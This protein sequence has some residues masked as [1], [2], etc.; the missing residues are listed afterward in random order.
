MGRLLFASSLHWNIAIEVLRCGLSQTPIRLFWL[1]ALDNSRFELSLTQSE[2]TVQW[3]VHSSRRHL[4]KEDAEALRILFQ[5]I[6][7]VVAIHGLLATVFFTDSTNVCCI[8]H[9]H[10]T[11][12]KKKGVLQLILDRKLVNVWDVHF[13]QRICH[14]VFHTFNQER[15][16]IWNTTVVSGYSCVFM[17]ASAKFRMSSLYRTVHIDGWG[18]TLQV[19]S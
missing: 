9:Y 6:R 10:H 17:E 3:V 8:C 7:A 12:K 18:K 13:R 2:H 1:L 16:K 5:C 4:S 11:S 14:V 19:R 15:L